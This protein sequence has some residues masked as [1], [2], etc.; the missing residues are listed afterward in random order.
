MKTL[1]LM[2][3]PKISIRTHLILSSIPQQAPFGLRI[4]PL[5]K[6]IVSWLTS[7]LQNH[8]EKE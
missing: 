5:S 4:N 7:L 2:L 8:P 3:Y 6:E 1:F